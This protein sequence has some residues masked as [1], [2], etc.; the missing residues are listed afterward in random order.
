MM[1]ASKSIRSCSDDDGDKMTKT[2]L[3]MKTSA[4]VYKHTPH[5]SL[6]TDGGGGGSGIVVDYDDDEND[7][8]A[9]QSHR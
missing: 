9:Y 6:L 5:S 2:T 1:M 3:T 8:N 7:V 4:V